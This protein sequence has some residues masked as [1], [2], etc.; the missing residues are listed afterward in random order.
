MNLAFD[1][2]G[3]VGR[4]SRSLRWLINMFSVSFFFAALD[5]HFVIGGIVSCT[6]FQAVAHEAID[7]GKW[8][9]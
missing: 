1:V 3:N 9:F 4:G 8:D 5:V 2:A 7:G 6:I